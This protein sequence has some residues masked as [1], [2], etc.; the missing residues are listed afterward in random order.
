MLV[1]NVVAALLSLAAVSEATVIAHR[2]PFENTL[3]RRQNRNGGNR[4][5]GNQNQNQNQN[6]GAANQGAANQGAAQDAALC[7]NANAVQTGSASTGQNG[8]VAAD[9]QVN[10]AT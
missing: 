3:A 2:S 1:K 9:G 4:N 7:L 5:G 6:Q 10:S 8:A